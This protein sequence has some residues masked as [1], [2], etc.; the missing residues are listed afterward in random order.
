MTSTQGREGSV[1]HAAPCTEH[2]NGREVALGWGCARGGCVPDPMSRPK[3]PGFYEQRNRRW[4][5]L[6]SSAL[7]GEE[8]GL[9]GIFRGENHSDA[10]HGVTVWSSGS[11][12]PPDH[13]SWW[14]GPSAQ[15]QWDISECCVLMCPQDL[16]LQ[17]SPMG[18]ATS[19]GQTLSHSRSPHA[20][21]Q[22]PELCPTVSHPA[23][24]PTLPSSLLGN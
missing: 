14:G 13:G 3:S 19:P 18:L 17:L 22:P 2:G 9:G 7:P 23:R 15:W 6:A 20:T 12:T 8:Y 4:V 5:A 24:L 11:V 16:S 21:G 10:E 1:A